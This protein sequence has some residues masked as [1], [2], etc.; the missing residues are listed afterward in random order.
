MKQ[1]QMTQMKEKCDCNE[2]FVLNHYENQWLDEGYKILRAKELKLAIQEM[3]SSNLENKQNI[4]ENDAYI[5][6]EIEFRNMELKHAKRWRNF[7]SLIT[8]SV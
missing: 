1:Y 6:K 5:K 8:N 2:S 7:S 4:E 3:N